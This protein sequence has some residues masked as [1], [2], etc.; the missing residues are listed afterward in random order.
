MIFHTFVGWE[1]GIEGMK[2]GG[3]RTLKIPPNLAYGERGMDNL[4]PANS[5]LQFEVELLK[6]PKPGVETLLAQSPGLPF[7]IG[8]ILF[9]GGAIALAPSK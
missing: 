1:Q 7:L 2:V 8:L 9:G 4:I 6:I 5:H 3:K